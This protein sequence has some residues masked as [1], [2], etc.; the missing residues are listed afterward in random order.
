MTMRPFTAPSDA[1]ARWT[2]VSIVGLAGVFV[3]AG[4]G[5]SPGPGTPTASTGSPDAQVK[6]F[7]DDFEGVCQGATVSKATVSKATVRPDGRRA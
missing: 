1:P 6:L 7:S 5:S 4:C 3:L 2:A